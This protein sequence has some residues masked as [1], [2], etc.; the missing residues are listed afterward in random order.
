M[1]DFSWTQAM[2]IEA[3]RMWSAGKKTGQI[4]EHFKAKRASVCSMMGRNRHLFPA[5][6]NTRYGPMEAVSIAPI[7]II[8]DRVVRTT[9]SGAQVT[10]R[11]VPTIDG[12]AD[13]STP[14]SSAVTPEL[15]FF[16]ED[17]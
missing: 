3:A 5:R 8:P 14:P 6:R 10:L 16:G 2:K 1:T 13:S 9:F 12:Y 4:A 17:F 7:E 11:R 15:G